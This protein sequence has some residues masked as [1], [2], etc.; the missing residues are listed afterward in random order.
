MNKACAAGKVKP[1]GPF[2][3]PEIHTAFT[4]CR[5]CRNTCIAAPRLI[6][7]ADPLAQQIALLRPQRSLRLVTKCGFISLVE[8]RFLIQKAVIGGHH[9]QRS[10]E[11][12]DDEGRQLIQLRQ[13]LRH[14]IKGLPFRTLLVPKHVDL[15]VIDI[16]HPVVANKLP[17]LVLAH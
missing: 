10:I 17:A 15:V 8:C 13:R 14:S 6:A 9:D 16:D 4:C 12:I 5:T 3:H 1:G 11:A 2:R 7:S